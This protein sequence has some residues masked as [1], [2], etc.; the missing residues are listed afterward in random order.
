[1]WERPLVEIVLALDPVLYS[2]DG[3]LEEQARRLTAEN[4]KHSAS[5]KSFEQVLEQEFHGLAQTI[6]EHSDRLRTLPQMPVGLDPPTIFTNVIREL[7][8]KPDMARAMPTAHAHAVI[9]TIFRWE[10]RDKTITPNDL[11]DFR[12]ASAGLSQCRLILCE[13]GLRKTLCH[14]RLPLAEMHRMTVL[15]DRNEIIAH[16]L[17]L[18]GR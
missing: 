18:A 12:H 17:D 10:Y 4:A 9:H 13:K 7:L 14:R 3:Q 15:N 11:V 8:K 1:M 16:L 2:R 6:V 5:M